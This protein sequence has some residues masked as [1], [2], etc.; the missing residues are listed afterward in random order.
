MSEHV[1]APEKKRTGYTREMREAKRQTAQRTAS[2]RDA[3]PRTAADVNYDGPMSWGAAPKRAEPIRE[4]E[5]LDR[6]TRAP[7][8]QRDVGDFTFPQERRRP[9]WDYQ[10]LA[11]TIYNQPQPINEFH[12]QGWRPVPA[13]EAPELLT[14][15]FPSDYLDV[16]GTMRW[17][18]RPEHLSAQAREEDRQHAEQQQRDRIVGAT[19]GRLAKSSE[20]S[21][22]DLR[23]VRPVSLGV[24]VVGEV[25]SKGEPVRRRD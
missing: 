17:Y 4:E 18:W 25:G 2:P 1:S 8:G 16:R 14:P 6:L 5:S 19:E 7:R 10:L 3:Q 21:L 20:Q 22:S 13:T 15:G 24:E 9:G 11:L 12:R 23:G